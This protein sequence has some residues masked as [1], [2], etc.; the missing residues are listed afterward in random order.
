MAWKSCRSRRTT[1]DGTFTMLLRRCPGGSEMC[2]EAKACCDAS[3]G[4][5][6]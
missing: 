5:P 3:S 2:S 1:R 6:I 4:T